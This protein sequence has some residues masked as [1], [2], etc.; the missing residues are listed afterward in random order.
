MI[1]SAAVSDSF[2]GFFE[3]CI[4]N[5]KGDLSY[6]SGHSAYGWAMAGVLSD[7]VP[8]RHAQI[9]AR[10][11]EFARQRMVCGVHF[12]SDIAAG[13]RAAEWVLGSIRQE[14]DYSIEAAEAS[15]ELREVLG[16]PMQRPMSSQ[17]PATRPLSNQSN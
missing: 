5:V 12:A 15:V 1:L 13:K 11:A 4:T 17:P 3:P 2:V 16:L 14:M 7:L 8:E 10:A 6:P 9:E